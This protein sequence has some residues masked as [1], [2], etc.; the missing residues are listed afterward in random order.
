MGER[1]R[2]F[3]IGVRKAMIEFIR[4]IEIRYG[5]ESAI[6]TNAQRKEL[7]RYVK[8]SKVIDIEQQS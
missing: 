7:Q 6:V 8:E 3:W 5:L 2:V 1:E 4:A